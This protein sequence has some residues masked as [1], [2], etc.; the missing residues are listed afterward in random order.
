MKEDGQCYTP[1]NLEYLFRKKSLRHNRFIS[2][3]TTNQEV[4]MNQKVNK[5]SIEY[6]KR[7]K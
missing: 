2:L 1:I 7:Q 4:Y 5:L 3:K 6:L